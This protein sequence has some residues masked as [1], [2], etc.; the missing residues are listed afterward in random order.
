MAGE[1]VRVTEF[2]KLNSFIAFYSERSAM[3]PPGK[4]GPFCSIYT[5]LEGEMCTVGI[6]LKGAE[7]VRA[8]MHRREDDVERRTVHVPGGSFRLPSA[9]RVQGPTFLPMHDL[10]Q[11]RSVGPSARRLSLVGDQFA[12]SHDGRWCFARRELTVLTGGE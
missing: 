2:E 3:A 6:T 12:T 1:L 9:D 7:A 10:D 5:G 4:T 11:D 8:A